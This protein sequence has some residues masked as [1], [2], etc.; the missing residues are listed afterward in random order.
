[1]KAG[2][3]LAA[4][5]SLGAATAQTS[6]DGRLEELEEVVVTGRMPGPP[7]W[8]VSNGANTLWILPLI[9]AYPR[10]ME[11]QSARVEQLIAQSQEYI[12][13]PRALRG[14]ATMNPLALVRAAR[15]MNRS[16]RLPEGT[17]LEDVLPADLYQRFVALKSRYVPRDRDIE[18][19]TPMAA[20]RVLQE[21]V[22]E[23]EGLE[24]M[25]YNRIDS[26]PVIASQVN[27]WVKRNKRIRRTT[28]THARTNRVSYGEF[29]T[30]GKVLKEASE[31]TEF[32]AWEAACFEKFLAYFESGIEPVKRRANAW[33][34]GH[35]SDLVNPTPLFGG[36]N[37]CR[38]PPVLA[39]DST[40][41]AKLR[42]QNAALAESLADD[43]VESVRIS[44]ERWLS[45]AEAA[46]EK[47]CHHILD[48]RCQ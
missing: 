3:L 12:D 18:R 43:G 25:L 6:D 16:T 32:T 37:A 14:I 26:P 45:A 8:K 33:A 19:L 38:N 41:L 23:R 39:A 17:T 30:I 29:G 36:S 44:K 40:A 42:K 5:L 7:L 27:R 15:S 1:M 28:P 21:S 20:A 48:A 13:R 46:L 4:V 34:Q 35:T 2:A 9:D 11:W 47:Q 31:S 24:L 10:Q 22:L